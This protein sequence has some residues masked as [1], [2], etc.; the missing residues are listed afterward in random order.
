MNKWSFISWLQKREEKATGKVGEKEKGNPKSY[1]STCSKII[2]LCGITW[3]GSCLQKTEIILAEVS[4]SDAAPRPAQQVSGQMVRD[5]Q[6]NLH[7][8]PQHIVPLFGPSS[9]DQ[10]PCWWVLAS[11]EA[12]SWWEPWSRDPTLEY[13]LVQPLMYILSLFEKKIGVFP[14]RSLLSLNRESCF[15]FFFFYLLNLFS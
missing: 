10:A 11:R 15:S 5:S 8:Q 4:S 14:L 7:S 9:G 12:G 6:S 3:V 2:Y 13:K 1:P